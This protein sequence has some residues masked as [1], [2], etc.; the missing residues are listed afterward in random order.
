MKRNYGG[1]F[2]FVS[3][4]FNV[5]INIII[6]SVKRGYGMFVGMSKKI[7]ICRYAFL[8]IWKSWVKTV[9]DFPISHFSLLYNDFRPSVLSVSFLSKFSGW[10]DGIFWPFKIYSWSCFSLRTVVSLC[11]NTCKILLENWR[12]SPDWFCHFG[13]FFF[14]YLTK[15][16]QMLLLFLPSSQMAIFLYVT[17]M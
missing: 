6:F 3:T 5:I 7:E 12:L 14:I 13:T 2:R 10:K 15:C 17:G 11:I 9:P 16:L 8:W 4:L 1:I